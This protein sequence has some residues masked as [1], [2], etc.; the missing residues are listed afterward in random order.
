MDGHLSTSTSQR[1]TPQFSC[2]LLRAQLP[3]DW[4]GIMA[5]GWIPNALV[6]QLQRHVR[7][8]AVRT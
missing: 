5:G 7:R 8:L 3:N 6:R 1:L 4:A 2:G